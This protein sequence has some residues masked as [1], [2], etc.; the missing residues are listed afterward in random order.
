MDVAP[1]VG[2]PE[3]TTVTVREG[4]VDLQPMNLLEGL[5]N[6][7]IAADEVVFACS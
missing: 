3:G 7:N 4:L 5:T 6:L 2:M 1:P